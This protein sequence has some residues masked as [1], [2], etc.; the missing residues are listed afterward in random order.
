MK[1]ISTLIIATLFASIALAQ[2]KNP[3]TTKEMQEKIKQ[4][5]EQLNKLTPEQKKYL[6]SWTEGT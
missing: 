3:T 5:Q 2:S 4:A 1:K 6:A